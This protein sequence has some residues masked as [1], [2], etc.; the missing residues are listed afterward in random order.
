MFSMMLISLALGTF[1]FPCFTI[2][3]PYYIIILVTDRVLHNNE[4]IHNF[5]VYVSTNKGN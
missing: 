4:N 3:G 5:K 1:P 2:M